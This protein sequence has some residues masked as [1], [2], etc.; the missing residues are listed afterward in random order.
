VDTARP[1][2]TRTT[3]EHLKKEFSEEICGQ[4]VFSTGT[5]T[6]ALNSWVETTAVCVI[7]SGNDMA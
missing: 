3:K 1:Q 4:Q 7:S 5:E 2:K 6:A